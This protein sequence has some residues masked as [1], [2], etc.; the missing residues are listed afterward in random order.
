MDYRSRFLWLVLLIITCN[1]ILASEIYD[2]QEI[3]ELIEKE[4]NEIEEKLFKPWQ[5]QSLVINYRYEFCNKDANRFY[6]HTD[7][8]DSQALLYKK[9]NLPIRIFASYK[10]DKLNL[11]FGSYRPAFGLGNIYKKYTNQSFLNKAGATSQLDL[12]GAFLNYQASLGKLSVFYSNTDVN[13]ALDSEGQRKIVYYPSDPESLVQS[14]LIA[15]MNFDNLLISVLTA[16]YKTSSEL[17][18]LSHQVKSYLFSS[19]LQYEHESYSLNYETNYHFSELSHYFKAKFINEFLT[20]EIIFQDLPEHSL[21]WFNSGISNKFNANTRLY[22]INSSFAL[23]TIDVSMG[24]ELKSNHEINHWTSKSFIEFSKNKQI[25]YYLQQDLYRDYQNTEHEKYTHKL[26]CKLFDFSNSQIKF[27]Y[28]LNNKESSG[29]ANMYQVNYDLKGE[30]GYL[31]LNLK[32]LD[33]YK[34]EEIVQDI[35]ENIIETFYDFSEDVI[36]S[37]NFRSKK[38]KNF[39]FKGNL[40]HS[41]YNEN[42]SSLKLE[43]SYLL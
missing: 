26:A 39:I 25:S 42:L 19:F 8:D 40:I 32:V 31:R 36:I 4:N 38:Y 23:A 24:A 13:T 16:R 11:G 35:D 2:Y 29:I 43:L 41:L 33:N 37:L 6:F 12:R 5:S 17:E 30:Y 28:T 22:S 7:L 21:N 9:E 10:T 18:Q 27:S 14:G 20:S 1:L 3:D 15:T 34:N